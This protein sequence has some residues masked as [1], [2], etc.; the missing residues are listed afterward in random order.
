MLMSLLDKRRLQMAV[1]ATMSG[2]FPELVVNG[3]FSQ[4]TADDPDGWIVAEVGDA[5]SNVTRDGVNDAV[6][7]IADGSGALVGIQQNILENGVQYRI[8]ID[9][10]SI[11]GQL[12]VIGVGQSFF[13]ITSAGNYS[14]VFTANG[15]D[16][17][18]YQPGGTSVDAIV[19]RA[20]VKRV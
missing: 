8:E 7:I 6:R 5:T 10:D 19:S 3:D 14:D 17:L 20:S 4:W 12:Q 1:A 16:F 11:T 15:P 9:V 13:V 18:I 2:A